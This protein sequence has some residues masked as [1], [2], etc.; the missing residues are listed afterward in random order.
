MA[1]QTVKDLNEGVVNEVLESGEPRS[2]ERSYS[3][4][5]SIS[6]RFGRAQISWSLDPNYAIGEKDCVQL[7]E[8]NRWIKNW[9]VE[10]P[11]GTVDTG[12]DWGTGLNASYW[13]WDYS[14]ND[15]RQLVHTANT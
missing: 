9:D 11:S 15:W 6:E 12:R 2:A 5:V 1:D 13:A 10:S 7:R 8:D 14:I 4:K 3:F